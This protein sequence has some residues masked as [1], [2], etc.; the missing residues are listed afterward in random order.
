MGL[1]G[2]AWPS[3]HSNFVAIH[4]CRKRFDGH[5]HPQP[6][7]KYI[8]KLGGL[9]PIHLMHQRGAQGL[10]WGARGPFPPA[11]AMVVAVVT[12]VVF[13]LRLLKN[14]IKTLKIV[15]CY[16]K[17]IYNIYCK[18]YCNSYIANC[19]WPSPICGVAGAR[20]TFVQWTP[21]Y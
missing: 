1:L 6:P 3:K 20:T 11:A 5:K 14:K 15:V 21:A 19:A 4:H 16:Q 17:F 7:P 8:R 9:W 10:L 13:V 12:P 18:T 2:C